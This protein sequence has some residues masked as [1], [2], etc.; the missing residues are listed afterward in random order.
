[1]KKL[2]LLAA[3]L[4]TLFAGAASAG[5][6]HLT[7]DIAPVC[8]VTGFSS[9]N[10]DR[11]FATLTDGEVV[12]V[13]GISL[14]CNDVDGAT[15]KLVSTEGGLESDDDE[16]FALTYDAVLDVGG[17]TLTLNA[18]GG[19]GQNDV[20]VEKNYDGDV[21]VLNPSASLT[22]TLTEDGTYA[23]G[24]SDTLQLSITAL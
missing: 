21:L 16:D 18:P 20:A 4:T 5:D 22:V 15:V 19:P 11:Q 3:S 9:G 7:G 10:I 13:S 17:D 14:N 2:T 6:V 1:M 12:T 23:G 24:W 8:E